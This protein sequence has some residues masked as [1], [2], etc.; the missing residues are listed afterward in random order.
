VCNLH[1]LS[2]GQAVIRF[3]DIWTANWTSVRKLTEGE[4]TNDL[5]AF[6]TTEPNREVGAIHPKAMPAILTAPEE[7]EGWMAAPI[8]EA[9]HP[10][11]A[12]AGW[13]AHDCGA[14]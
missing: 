2:K 14:G 4:T 6:L 10:A 3:A 7:I 1:S 13:S 12:V 9:L 8:E 11:T 5:Y